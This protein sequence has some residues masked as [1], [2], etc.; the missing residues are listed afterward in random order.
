ML[1][2][3][4]I[5]SIIKL[6]QLKLNQLYNI[7]FIINISQ[8]CFERLGHLYLLKNLPSIAFDKRVQNM[9]NI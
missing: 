9:W 8:C 5:P 3:S 4:H 1:I 6:N 7:V 2:L